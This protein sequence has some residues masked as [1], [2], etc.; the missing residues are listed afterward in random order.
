M[1]VSISGHGQKHFNLSH[2]NYFLLQKLW[3]SKA[4]CSLCPKERISNPVDIQDVDIPTSLDKIQSTGEGGSP[5]NKSL[6]FTQ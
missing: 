3:D 2:M 4:G 6:L 1:C 5:A